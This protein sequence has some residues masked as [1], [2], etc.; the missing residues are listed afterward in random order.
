MKRM[1]TSVMTSPSLHLGE[2]VGA[3]LGG[4][5]GVAAVRRIV[6]VGL[7]LGLG[8]ERHVEVVE[9]AR[10]DRVG[11]VQALLGVIGDAIGQ[12]V[13][14]LAIAAAAARRHHRAKD[15]YKRER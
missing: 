3:G 10:R 2:V 5:I 4:R 12:V 6:H 14:V 8:G 11:L 13:V 7:A 9:Q 15:E 1:G